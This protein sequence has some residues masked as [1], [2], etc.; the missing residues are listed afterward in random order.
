MKKT[1]LIAAA[2]LAASVISSQAQVYSQNIVGYINSAV[3]ANYT[4]QAVQLNLSGGNSLTNVIQN[5]GGIYDGSGVFLWNGTGYTQYTIDSGFVSGVGDAADAAGVPAPT[6][7]P[8]TAFLFNNQGVSNNITYVGTVPVNS[9]PGTTTN[10][11]PGDKVLTLV[12]SVLPVGG[13]I[14]TSLGFTNAA[15]SLDGNYVFVPKF[16]GGVQTGFNQYTFDSGFASGFGDAADAAQAPEPQIPVGGGFF[17]GNQ[18]GIT[19]TWI[20]SL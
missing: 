17:Y 8:G 1:L 16:A 15:G 5:P 10:T 19:R 18:D 9:L 13:G 3:P 14:S 7:A 20:Q 6:L 11:I 4:L 2:A 12:A